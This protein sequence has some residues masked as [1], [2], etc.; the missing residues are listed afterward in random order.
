MRQWYVFF[1]PRRLPLPPFH[2]RCRDDTCVMIQKKE[3]V[4]GPTRLDSKNYDTE[5]IVFC[6]SCCRRQLFL[7]SV[8]VSMVSIDAL[9]GL[10]IS[11]PSSPN[12]TPHDN[13]EN[14]L[15]LEEVCRQQGGSCREWS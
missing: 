7:N 6:V 9:D 12:I 2:S 14:M 8:I 4:Y 10:R 11:C 3:E 1:R 5:D 15:I 13:D